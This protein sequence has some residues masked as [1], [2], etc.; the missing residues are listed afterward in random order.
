MNAPQAPNAGQDTLMQSMLNQQ[1]AV[2]Q[3]QLNMVN[4]N[5]PYGSLT[6]A[7]DPNAPGGYSANTTLSG[8][9]Q[10]VFNNDMSAQ[11]SE[12]AAAA[13]LAASGAGALGGGAPDLGFSGINA[14]VN[15]D[16]K[17]TLDPQWAAAGNTEAATLAGEGIMP[18]SESY[19]TQMNNFDNSKNTAYDQMFTADQG[20]AQQEALTAYNAPVNAL[21]AM[22]NGAP[23]TTPNSSFVATPQESISAPNYMGAVQSNYQ[24]ATSQYDAMLGGISGLGGTLGGAAIKGAFASDR[25]MKT[26]IDGLGKDPKTGLQMYAYRYKGDPKSYPKTV[27]PMAQDIEKKAPGAVRSIGG[28]KVV[29]A[30]GLGLIA[31]RRAA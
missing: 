31:R 6:Y 1:S 16:E 27:G 3:Q 21:S 11:G 7:A 25:D 5:G 13:K 28:H 30:G 29:K 22:E 18:G 23:V 2:E 26:D 10:T 15:A 14:Q 19:T 9:E 17:N 8:P 12:S 24:N 4:Q 20:Q